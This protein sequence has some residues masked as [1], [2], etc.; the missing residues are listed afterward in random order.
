MVSQKR[1]PPRWRCGGSERM[2]TVSG[3]LIIRTADRETCSADPR[4]AD[5]GA[6]PLTVDRAR[7]AAV[8]ASGEARHLAPL[9]AAVLD[10]GCRLLIVS[11]S[12]SPSPF[13]A[14]GDRPCIG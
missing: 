5:L 9:Y 14:P 3:P 8:I 10:G 4:Q 6:R 12:A 1:E 13:R 11:Q 2:M 7:V